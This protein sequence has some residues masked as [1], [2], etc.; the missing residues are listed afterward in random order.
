M[1]ITIESTSKIVTLKTRGGA[2]M[3]ARIWEG[4]TESGIPIHCFVT[5]VAAPNDGTDL[6]E[7]ERELQAH[8][9]PSAP[10][11]ALPLRFFID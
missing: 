2:E 4:R 5:R 8:A 10:I 11:E 3:P 6:S 7:F 1:K 9:A